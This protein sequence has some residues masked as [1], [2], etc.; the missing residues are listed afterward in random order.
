MRTLLLRAHGSSPRLT[1]AGSATRMG[2]VVPRSVHRI[3][4]PRNFDWRLLLSCR[5]PDRYAQ[6]HARPPS[7]LQQSDW[8]I[9][10]GPTLVK[11]RA[12]RFPGHFRE[13]RHASLCAGHP[14]RHFRTQYL[15]PVS[16]R[17]LLSTMQHPR[18][19]Q[20]IPSEYYRSWCG[21]ARGPAFCPGAA[22]WRSTADRTNERSVGVTNAKTTTSPTGLITTA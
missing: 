6:V 2:Q 20:S 13:L 14:P 16:L 18:S 9:F 17:A 8:N 5:G 10:R 11:S 4:D 3:N 21:A 22:E 12:D 1:G 15:P 19:D 7:T